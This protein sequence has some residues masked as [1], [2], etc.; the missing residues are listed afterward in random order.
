MKRDVFPMQL[1]ERQ[2]GVDLVSTYPNISWGMV[3]TKYKL[4]ENA[5][6]PL[7]SNWNGMNPNFCHQK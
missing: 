2:L 4:F 1:A 3:I 7:F 6:R 5:V